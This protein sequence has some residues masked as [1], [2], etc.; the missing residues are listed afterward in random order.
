MKELFRKL[1][2]RALL[3]RV[4]EL[5]EAVPGRAGRAVERA[6]SSSGARPASTSCARSPTRWRSRSAAAAR[7][8]PRD[9]ADVL[10]VEAD[11]APCRRGAA[12]PPRAHARAQAPG[13]HAGRRHGHRRLPAR[14]RPGG[15]R[16]RR[17]GRGDRARAR[18]SAAD[19]ETSALVRAAAAARRLHPRAAERARRAGD[20]RP[21]RA[22]SSCRSCPCWRRWRRPA[23]ASTPTAWPRSPPSSPTRSRSSRRAAYELAGG[24]FAIGLAEAARRGAVRAARPARRPQGQDRLLHRRARAGQDPPHAPDRGRGR[25]VARA[26]EAPEHLPGAAA[27]P[28]R[29]RRRPPAHDVQP[30]DRRHRPAVVDPPEPAEHPHPHAARARDPQRLRGRRRLQAAVGRLLAGRAAHPRPPLG[31]ARAARGV[32]PRRGHPPR[33][34]RRRCWAS[35]PRR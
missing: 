24:P 11:T 30:D 20:D 7:R 31:R 5:E 29:C 34:R 4:D 33:D 12:R 35:R 14:P 19:E 23:S 27:R 2:F 32:R 6:S 21:L 15:L 28:D 9:G 16:D 22:T 17:P 18:R 3:K 13:A 26:V 25:A 1:E 10:V 8:S